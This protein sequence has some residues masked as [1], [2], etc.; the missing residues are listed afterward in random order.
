M[1]NYIVKNSQNIFDIAIQLYGSVEGIYDLLISNPQLS[2]DTELKAGMELIY[3]DYFVINDNIVDEIKSKNL[4]PT[5]SER[6]VYYK[7]VSAPQILQFATKP[8]AETIQFGVS[9][10]GAMIVDWG[11]NSKLETIVLTDS[12]SIVYHSFDNVVDERVIRIYGN[13]SFTQL[14]VSGFPSQLYLL[15]GLT[16]DEFTCIGNKWPLDCLFLFNG[17]YMV[18]LRNSRISDLSPLLGLSLQKLD[19]RGAD[20]ES[21]DVLDDYLV[22]LVANYGNRRNCEVLLTTAPSKRGLDAI[23]TIINEPEWNASG[24]W[25]FIINGARVET[26]FPYILPFVFI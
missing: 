15:R 2:M 16:V 18:D 12:L 1:A 4:C 24:P 17:T 25:V 11:D 9:G 3:H 23:N 6:S 20:F 14:D 19:L 5:N 13:F 26:K 7:E 10:S 8:N 21:V 22:Q